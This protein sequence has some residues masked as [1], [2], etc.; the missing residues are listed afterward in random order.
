MVGSRGHQ[1][2][3]RRFRCDFSHIPPPASLSGELALVKHPLSLPR[4]LLSSP[5]GQPRGY[6]VDSSQANAG[7]RRLTA[8]FLHTNRADGER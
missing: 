1:L 2:P 8:T 3:N 7:V 6:A 4:L 5:V